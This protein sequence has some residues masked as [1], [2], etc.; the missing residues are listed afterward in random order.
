MTI[1]ATT[2]MTTVV[3][4]RRCGGGGSGGSVRRRFV[5]SAGTTNRNHHHEKLLLSRRTAFVL[6]TTTTTFGAVPAPV[7]ASTVTSSLGVSELTRRGMSKFSGGE[8]EAS[9]EDF[10]AVVALDARYANLMWQRGLS[11]YY[12]GEYEEA[13]K[14]FR[15]D[16]DV[17]PNDT[18]ESVWCFASEAM[19]PNKGLEYARKNQL[20]TGR[21]S[22]RV[23]ASVYALG[24]G[25]CR[26]YSWGGSTSSA[27]AASKTIWC[28]CGSC[29]G[30]TS[31]DVEICSSTSMRW[32][33]G[34]WAAC[35]RALGRESD[36]VTRMAYDGG[37]DQPSPE[38]T[39]GG[40][41]GMP[42]CVPSCS[43]SNTGRTSRF[44]CNVCAAVSA[45]F[46]KAQ[47]V[48]IVRGSSLQ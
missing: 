23:M 22:R 24:V 34:S 35:A 48:A 9:V 10:D 27:A 14:Q 16:V 5:V 39:S 12:T 33:G 25:F 30:P 31:T 3:S 29:S 43:A 47:S 46:L 41:G 2:S 7:N 36:G 20:V 19:D 15:K 32:S 13:A 26:M 21:D 42:H 11:L 44:G 45:S 17:N 18:E 8:V 40:G 28:T 4:M 6:M 1:S 37:A 38:A